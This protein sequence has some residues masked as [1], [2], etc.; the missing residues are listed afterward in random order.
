MTWRIHCCLRSWSIG[1]TGNKEGFGSGLFVGRVRIQERDGGNIGK[2]Q[3]KFK[4]SSKIGCYKFE[5]NVYKVLTLK[6]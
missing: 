5:E 4:S 2:S 6:F 3:S 1:F